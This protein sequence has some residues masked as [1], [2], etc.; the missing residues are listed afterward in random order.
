MR[1]F[2]TE[3]H[4][5]SLILTFLVKARRGGRVFIL[6]CKPSSKIG[7]IWFQLFAADLKKIKRECKI[8]KEKVKHKRKK[9]KN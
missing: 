3:K 1:S 8:E 9:K 7:N 4:V 2:D 6:K 5:E